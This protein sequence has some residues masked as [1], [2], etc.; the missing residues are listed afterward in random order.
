M[1]DNKIVFL[2]FLIALA[3]RVI[4]V[5]SLGNQEIGCWDEEGWEIAENIVSGNGYS[6]WV[7]VGKFVSARPWVFPFFLAGSMRVFGPGLLPVELMLCLFSGLGCILIYLI[8][9]MIFGRKP[10]LLAML[11]A[12]F[13]PP[14]IY[15]NGKITPESLAILLLLLAVYFLLR[16]KGGYLF[17]ALLSGAFLG[18]LAM[19]RSMAYG[20]IPLLAFWVFFTQKDK[21]RALRQ[22]LIM[23]IAAG[24]LIAPWVIR[25][26][27]LHKKIVLASTEGGM[28][29]YATHNPEVLT[30][31]GGDF[32]VLGLSPREVAGLSE[33]QI[34]RYYYN[35]GLEFIKRHPAEYRKLLAG[36][37]LRF[38]R[39]FPHTTDLPDSY[40]FKHILVMLFTDGPLIILGAIGLFL[41]AAS[42]F[43][44][45]L[46]FALI[47][48]NFNF[49]SVLVRSCIRYRT[50]IMPFLIIL[51]AYAI[52]HYYLRIRS[53]YAAR[54]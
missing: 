13:Y 51:S 41:L 2:L 23:V 54:K 48:F 14:F 16:N 34:D 45:A 52:Y 29:F 26:Y 28:T 18:A 37:F 12:V 27:A 50:M 47:I 24:L 31:G 49:V 20:L 46:L 33:T 15:W 42:R 11:I 53:G 10:A 21:R 4:Y 17:N 3:V 5:Y 25:N 9:K 1:K 19:T 35:K 38:W 44:Y 7:G 30:K 32:Y 39:F 22:A 40:N 43:S 8:A 6:M 36:R